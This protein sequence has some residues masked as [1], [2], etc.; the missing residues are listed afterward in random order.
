MAVYKRGR[1]W[2]YKFNWNG[3]PG[4]RPNSRRG[5]EVCWFSLKWREGA[6]RWLVFCPSGGRAWG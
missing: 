1:V 3:E 2:W 5:T 4:Q 6:P